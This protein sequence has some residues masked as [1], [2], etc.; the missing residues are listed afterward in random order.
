MVFG[1]FLES[2][3]VVYTIRSTDSYSLGMNAHLS[4]PGMYAQV[5]ISLIVNR[6]QSQVIIV[7]DHIESCK[8]GCWSRFLPSSSPGQQ[9]F[10][11]EAREEMFS[12]FQ[13]I[14]SLQQ[15]LNSAIVCECSIRACLHQQVCLCYTD[16]WQ[17]R[18]DAGSVLKK[19]PAVQ[20]T[21]VW[22]LGQKDPLE[23]GMATQSSTLAW[24]IPWTE[25]PGGL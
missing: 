21:Q 12:A 4:P 14:W 7:P 16:R 23:K 17:V 25:E 22:A 18:F 2:K 15:R 5:H 6:S 10:P 13:T 9:P 3:S 8:G 20:E 24:R 11:V 1:W 19:L